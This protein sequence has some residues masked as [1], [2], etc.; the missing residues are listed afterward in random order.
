MAK[1]LGLLLVVLLIPLP[2][3]E[4]PQAPEVSPGG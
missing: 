4:P 3:A 2:V 1:W